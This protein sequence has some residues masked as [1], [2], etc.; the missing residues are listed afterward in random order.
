[1]CQWI[2]VSAS[3]AV[4]SPLIAPAPAL[5]SFRHHAPDRER[6]HVF[7]GWD[8]ASVFRCLRVRVCVCVCV[9][10]GRIEQLCKRDYSISDS[11]SIWNMVPSQL[12][13]QWC[14]QHGAAKVQGSLSCSR[15]RRCRC[16]S[17]STSIEGKCAGRPRTLHQSRSTRQ[18]P[19]TLEST[20]NRQCSTVQ[21][22]TERVVVGNCVRRRLM[23]AKS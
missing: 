22:C 4:M 17:V 10:K 2:Y 21:A 12:V 23:Y 18:H 16:S 11:D 9:L 6:T 14:R 7:L 19:H 3:L 15:V 13:H 8:T 1:L 5:G 20:A